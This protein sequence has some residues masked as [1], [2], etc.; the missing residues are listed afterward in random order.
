MQVQVIS[1]GQ[2][3]T[4]SCALA[5]NAISWGPAWVDLTLS[6]E[7]TLKFC[8]FGGQRT[9]LSIPGWIK[10]HR[11]EFRNVVTWSEHTDQSW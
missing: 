4:A 7:D 1:V 11:E 6:D 5:W 10:E 2:S 8:G 9:A 3:V